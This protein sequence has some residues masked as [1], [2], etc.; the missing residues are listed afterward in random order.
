METCLRG[1]KS[2]GATNHPW[3][4]REHRHSNRILTFIG[5]ALQQNSLYADGVSEC[6]RTRGSA[7]VGRLAKHS[8]ADA[9]GDFGDRL[10]ALPAPQQKRRVR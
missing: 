1:P 4:R 10:A 2:S 7:A 3:F 9:H 5:A 8:N 6:H